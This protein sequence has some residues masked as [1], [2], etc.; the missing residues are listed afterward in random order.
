L[1]F[2]ARAKRLGCTLDEIADLVGV[3]DGERCAPVQLRMHELVSGKLRDADRQIVEL[4]A[5]TGQL[6]TAATLLAGE[7]IDGPCDDACAC[8]HEPPASVAASFGAEPGR[9]AIACTLG[10]AD[11]ADR[12][13]EWNGLLGQVTRRSPMA[14]GGLRVEFGAIDIGALARLVEA[15][16]AC[17]SFLRF[18]ITVDQ[19]GVALEIDAPGEARAVVEALFGA[20][21]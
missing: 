16:Q 7:P 3:W 21:P 4:T 12:L 20:P 5:F 9:T 17:C 6:R 8:L 11:I 14:S 2:I 13:D 10:A 15:E 18:A 1:A 19:R